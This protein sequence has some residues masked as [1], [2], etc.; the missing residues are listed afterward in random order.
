MS[1][2]IRFLV[3]VFGV[4]FF[5]VFLFSLRN[6][7]MKPFYSALWMAVSF[8]MISLVFFEKVF[9]SIATCLGFDDASFL[10]IVGLI[11]FLLLYVLH[12]SVKISEM[13][14]RIQELISFASIL[15]NKLRK[16]KENKNEK[17]CL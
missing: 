9:K 1:L 5:I 6:K 13:S 2:N 3:L 7:S 17:S 16:C 8:F 10:I 4:L 15:E 14:D 12:L 11:S